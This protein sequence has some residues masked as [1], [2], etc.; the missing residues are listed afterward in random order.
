MTIG[1]SSFIHDLITVAGGINIFK[2]QTSP[3]PTVSAE[4]VIRRRPNVVVTVDREGFLNKREHWLKLL[5]I[6][7]DRVIH[8]EDP[9]ILHRPSPRVLEGLDW[10]HTVLSRPK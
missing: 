10:L 9:D 7:A 8:S 4:A 6:A 3:W 1:G 2:D 5:G